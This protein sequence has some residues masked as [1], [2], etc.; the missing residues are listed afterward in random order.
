MD[1]TLFWRLIRRAR[2]PN[3]SKTMAIRNS[4]GK[5]VYEV[6]QVLESWREHFSR[7]CIPKED[8]YFDNDHYERV[9][10]GVKALNGGSEKGGFVDS[11]FTVY[12][13][14]K[15]INRLH[16]K[17]VCGY[18]DIS[19]EEIKFAGKRM[20]IVLTIIYN[21]VVEREYIPV[22]FRR[23]IQVPLFKGKNLDCLDSNNYCG[24]TLL[25][26]FNKLFEVLLWGRLEKWWV[27]SGVI[28]QLQGA[29]K[30]GQSC[31]HSCMILQ[32]TVSAALDSH[33][34]IFVSYYYVSK[35]F[36]T[37]WTDGLFW[38]LHQK[39]IRGKIWR[40]MY[41]SYMDFNCC[42][43]IGNECSDWYPMLCGIHQG[44]FLSLLKYS[45]FIDGLIRELEDSNL[46]CTIQ[47]L[48]STPLGY[49]DD[50]AAATISKVRRDGINDLVYNYGNTWRFSFDTKKLAV[51]LYGE[52]I[53]ENTRNSKDRIFRL[54]PDRIPERQE[55]D[56]V[57]IKASINEDNESR[58]SERICKSQRSLNAASGLGI[59]KNALNMITCNIIF[60]TIIVPILSFGC[61]MWVLTE[62]DKENIMAF[63]RFAGRRIQRLP[64]RSL[65]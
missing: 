48:K 26:N 56:H 47:S 1:K 40:L 52:S 14:E 27:S 31:V 41:R 38:K 34:Y 29:C 63:Q 23:G 43:G 59:R 35:A 36:D 55:Y 50:L 45:V 64:H 46:C 8:P 2:K 33:R 30:K 28:S 11:K 24:I 4:E 13:V 20:A 57:G 6:P 61:E 44:G 16:L 19:S 22:N 3:S 53:R 32:E 25:T 54:G 7:L 17:K 5:V 37:V 60:W 39:G 15:A 9:R 49:A 10:E 62:R 58:V 18:N 65:N 51:L 21:L 12:E 42:V